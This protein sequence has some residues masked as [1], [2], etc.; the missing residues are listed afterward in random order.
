MRSRHKYQGEKCDFIS[1]D[2]KPLSLGLCSGHY[3]QAQKGINLK[4]LK[5]KAANN[6][7]TDECIVDEC[8]DAPVAKNLCQVHY[9][10]AKNIIRKKKNEQIPSES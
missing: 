10:K 6:T 4:P 3:K 2:N 1:C 5:K 8:K 9:D 7:L